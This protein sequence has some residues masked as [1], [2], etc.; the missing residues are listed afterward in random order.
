MEIAFENKTGRFYTESLKKTKTVQEY[1]E[2][3][4]PDTNEDIAHISTVRTEVYIKSKDVTS[5]GVTVTGEIS[6]ALLYI[7]ESEDKLQTVSLKKQFIME[8]E[9][10]GAELSE[11]AVAALKVSNTETRILNPRKVAMTVEITG[12]ITAYRK[13]DELTVSAQTA[14]NGPVLHALK[15]EVSTEK[16]TVVTDKTFTVTDQFA[17]MPG[18][19]IPSRIVSCIADFIC[20][21]GQQVG[22]KVLMKGKARIELCYLADDTPYPIWLSHT[23]PFSQLADVGDNAADS[24]IFSAETVS[25]YADILDS[26]NGGKTVEAEIHAVIQLV[27]YKAQTVSFVSDMYS[28]LAPVH[29]KTEKLAFRTGAKQSSIT[30]TCAGELDIGEECCDVISI[31]AAITHFEKLGTALRA[32]IQTEAVYSLADKTLAT[33]R[34]VL[35]A[36]AVCE[37]NAV[38]SSASV[39]SSTLRPEGELISGEV[40][41]CFV[42]QTVSEASADIV[43]SAQYDDEAPYDYHSFPEATVVRAERETLWE[44]AE[45]Y[46]SSMEKITAFND[47]AD[48]NGKLIMIPKSI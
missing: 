35:T 28:N 14:E 8:A 16:I 17:I 2:T 33:A 48:I 26:I 12:E 41:V 38:L 7:T 9:A 37:E 43:V 30:A 15:R 6:A 42:T 20:E 40:T 44:L 47:C 23:V 11:S 25:A 39:L 22:N 27:G 32:T 5:R 1:L 3:V 46:H 45:R 24:F 4:V 18:K 19:A 21:D 29:C 36:E 13:A 31:S 34:R 10:D